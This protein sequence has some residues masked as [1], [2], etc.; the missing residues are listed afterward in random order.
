MSR[1]TPPKP[2]TPPTEPTEVHRD[3]P[4]LAEVLDV[5]ARL[6]NTRGYRAT[7]LNDI[8][9]E[10]G[11]NKASLYYYVASKQ[12]LLQRLILRA[13]QALRE[14]RLDP[15]LETAPPREA[16]EMMVRTHCGALLA[17]PDEFGT[18][19]LQRRY[20]DAE[21]LDPVRAHERE[22]YLALRRLIRR[23]IAEGVF[24][25]DLDD[26]VATLLVLDAANGLVRWYRPDGRL[27]GPAVTEQVWAFVR[28][29][30]C[31]EEVRP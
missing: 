30:L 2:A 9:A 13:A 17:R 3:P 21:V 24:R 29:A 10:L 4:R 16:L 6:F 19:I 31:P 22:Y 20:L 26:G 28:A 12:E 25:R 5:A 15:S 14:A 11:I 18:L 7:S 23:G 8:A 1:R 27:S